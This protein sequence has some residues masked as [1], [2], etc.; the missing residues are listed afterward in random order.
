MISIGIIYHESST[1]PDACKRSQYMTQFVQPT[2]FIE[3]PEECTLRLL[4][5]ILEN[6][7]LSCHFDPTKPEGF[8]LNLQFKCIR[9]L[10]EKECAEDPFEYFQNTMIAQNDGKIQQNKWIEIPHDYISLE[11]S[12]INNPYLRIDTRHDFI[13]VKQRECDLKC[14]AD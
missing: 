8:A 14:R 1:C 12:I 6:T 13:L 9:P 7:L 5:K 3:I 11:Y 4:Q 2:H 10:F